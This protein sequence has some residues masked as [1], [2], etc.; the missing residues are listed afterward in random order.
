MVQLWVSWKGRPWLGTREV[1]LAVGLVLGQAVVGFW[2]GIAEGLVVG[3]TEDF[4][5]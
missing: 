2:V 4:L 5:A 1:G 3:A